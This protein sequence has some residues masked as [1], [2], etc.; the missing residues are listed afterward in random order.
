MSLVKQSTL[1]ELEWFQQ[2]DRE[3]ERIEREY[4]DS[5]PVQDVM[6]RIAATSVTLLIEGQTVDGLIKLWREQA[7]AILKDFAQERDG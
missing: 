4:P 2:Q 3:R 5:K 6:L 1:D 7:M